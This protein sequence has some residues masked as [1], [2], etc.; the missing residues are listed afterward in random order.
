MQTM[1]F[2]IPTESTPIRPREQEAFL[3]LKE[4]IGHNR[5][6]SVIIID[7]VFGSAIV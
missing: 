3:Q 7:L 1:S 2:D 6:F 5:D 4:N